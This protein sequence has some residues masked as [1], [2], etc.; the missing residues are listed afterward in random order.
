MRQSGLRDKRNFIGIADFKIGNFLD[1]FNQVNSIVTRRLVEPLPQRAFDLGMSGVA[2][3]HHVLALLA[4][5]R[6]LHVHLGD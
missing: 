6:D 3:Q 5:A 2:D 1:T 4:V